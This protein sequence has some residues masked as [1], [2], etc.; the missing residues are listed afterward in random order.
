MLYALLNHT[1]LKI[2]TSL[3]K[4]A[5]VQLMYKVVIG[6]ISNRENH[7]VD[8]SKVNHPYQEIGLELNKWVFN[9]L[10]IGFYYRFGSYHAGSFRDDFAVKDTLN[11]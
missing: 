11:L 6:N 1:I 2:R 7:S 5:N 10:G 8:F 4:F 9:I 3:Q